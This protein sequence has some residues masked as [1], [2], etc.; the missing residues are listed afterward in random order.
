MS[1]TIKDRYAD[2]V[3]F[4]QDWIPIYFP[5]VNLYLVG[6][7]APRPKNPVI[8]FN[9]LSSID[10]IGQD[11]RR[12]DEGGNETLRGQRTLICDLFGFSESASR[13]DGED[14]AWDMLQTLRMSLAFPAVHD[15]LSA[16]NCSVVDEGT[17]TDVSETLETTNEP[18]AML[19]ITFS[20]VIIQDID[21]G[22]IETVNGVGTLIGS[23]RDFDVNIS[24]TKP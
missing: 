18:R 23:I 10:F 4:F 17:V 12:I 2:L 1:D 11:E 5:N 6:Q 7:S 19:Q 22:A 14:N 21:S 24:V 20:T 9:P 15:M 3:K 16:I 8:A 13:F